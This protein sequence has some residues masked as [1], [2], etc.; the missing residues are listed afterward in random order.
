MPNPPAVFLAQPCIIHVC[1]FNTANSNFFTV[2][3]RYLLL[4]NHRFPPLH[5]SRNLHRPAEWH[6]EG[7]PTPN[8]SDSARPSWR[9]SLVEPPS[10]GQSNAHLRAPMG[11]KRMRTCRTHEVKHEIIQM[12]F[13]ILCSF[14]LNL[15]SGSPAR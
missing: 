8:P 12:F 2:K 5:K 13:L 3:L 1:N 10:W 7:R 11:H 6:V 9:L 14:K 15:K 4:Q